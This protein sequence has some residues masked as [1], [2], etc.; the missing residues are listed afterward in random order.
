MALLRE[1]FLNQDRYNCF[2]SFLIEVKVVTG[3]VNT[4]ISSEGVIY[5]VVK[6]IAFDQ[7]DELE[8][9]RW[10][11]DALNAV[12]QHFIPKMSQEDQDRVINTILARM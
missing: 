3:H 6:S 5:Y 2:E 4:H 11:N 1:V 7:M 9:G 8:F 12:F 10:K